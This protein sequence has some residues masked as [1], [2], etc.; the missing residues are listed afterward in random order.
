[1]KIIPL[2]LLTALPLSAATITQWN[3]N[4]AVAD[5]DVATGR[6]TPSTGSGTASLVNTTSVFA[7][8]D[9]S[10]GST[11]PAAG[12]DSGWGVLNFGAGNLSS[13]AQFL[14]DTTGYE[15]ITISYDVRHSNTSSRYQAIQYTLNG[16]SWTTLSYVATAAGDIWNNGRSINFSAITG[17]NNNPNFGVRILSAF[18]STANAGVGA[19]AFVAANTG[20]TYASGGNWRFDM[21]TVSGTV[22][23]EPSAALLGGLGALALLRRRR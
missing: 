23:P 15:S 4:S 2:L 21:V 6:T 7:S 9:A 16:S 18:E 13:G 11:D 12:D 14:V 20:S 22:I 3:F 1:M 19:N 10:G 8:G 5:A 17:A